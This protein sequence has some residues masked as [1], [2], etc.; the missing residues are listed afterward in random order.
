[1]I[2]F[3]WGEES[4]RHRFHP[5]EAENRPSSAAIAAARAWVSGA[6]WEDLTEDDVEDLTGDQIISGIRRHYLGGWLAFL[7]DVGLER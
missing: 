5:S 1:M 4:P 3:I 7:A 6:H 2:S